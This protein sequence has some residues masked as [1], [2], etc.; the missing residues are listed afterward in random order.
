[1]KTRFP[2]TFILLTAWFIATVFNHTHAENLFP[3]FPSDNTVGLW[4]FD[5]QNYP[6]TTL[7]DASLNEYDLR[8]MPG[9]QLTKG[10]Y[11]NALE[12]TPGTDLALYFAGWKGAHVDAHLRE[13]DGIPSGLLGPNV[14]PK[15]LLATL[16]NRNWTIEFRLKLLS[17]PEGEA[18]ILDLGDANEPGFEI[19]LNG[20]TGIFTVENLYRGIIAACP[21]ADWTL[22]A[23]TWQHISFVYNAKTNTLKYFLNGQQQTGVAVKAMPRLD[24]PPSVEPEDLEHDSFGFKLTSDTEW[25]K[26]HRFRFNIGH[27]NEGEKR[28]HGSIDE[29]RISKIARYDEDFTVAGSFSRNYGKDAP[30]IN[31]ADGP[32]L[33]FATES[34][35][36]PIQLGSR[37][38]LFIDDA[39]I[40]SMQNIQLDC[41][42]PTQPERLNIEIDRNS[43]RPGVIDKDGKVLMFIPEGYSSE[44]GR[45]HLRI[46]EDGVNFETPNLGVIKYEGSTNNDLVLHRVPLYGNVWED[47]NPNTPPIER[48]KLTAWV[49]NRGIYMYL[50]P[51]AIHWRRNETIMLPLVSGGEAETF[52]DDQRGLY[53]T[54]LKRDSSFNTEEHRGSGRCGILFETKDIRKAWPF[55]KLEQPYYESWPF[56]AVVAEGP[57]VF[58]VNRNG[59]VYRTR[60]IKYPWAPDTYLAFVWRYHSDSEERQVDLGVSR[61]GVHWKFFADKTWYLPA[62]GTIDGDP[63]VEKLSLY[64]LIRRGDEIWQYAEHGKGAHGDGKRAYFRYTQRLDGFTSLNAGEETGTIRTKPL[65]FAGNRLKLNVKATDYVRI[66]ITNEAGKPFEGFSIKDCNYIKNDSAN[67]TVSWRNGADVSSLEGK[68]V[69]LVLEMR[70]AKLYAIEFTDR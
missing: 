19:S 17:I 1:M 26:A 66:S 60:A 25:R 38:H 45:T 54:Y 62:E 65:V 67:H 29:L 58:P 59:E 34:P 9:G 49:A 2:I 46:S 18:M 20:S 15:E 24:V 4:L 14:A 11:G 27:D 36:G 13:E 57:V 43:W 7:T 8:L 47:L 5:E 30:P 12:V 69:R 61:D 63:V 41:N 50:S 68:T 10:V 64:G 21:T 53:V 39:L 51:D 37:R 32:P 3:E 6:H 44:E 40:D 55:R 48:Y 56:P 28:L 22:Q 23:D 33:L 42:P 35:S 70:K 16:A 52:W 31:Q